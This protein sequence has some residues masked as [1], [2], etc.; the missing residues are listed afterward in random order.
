MTTTLETLA[1]APDDRVLIIHADDVGFCHA[2]NVAVFEGMARGSLTCASALVAAPWF[3][4]TARLCREQP[5][6]DMG[7]HLALNCEHEIFRWR[8]VSGHPSLHAADGGVWRTVDETAAHVSPETARAE[9]FAQVQLA[10]DLGVDVTHVDTH[11]GTVIRPEYLSAYVDVAL[12]F[13]LP[14]FFFGAR[15]RWLRQ[16]GER[17]TRLQPLGSNL[18]DPEFAALHFAGQFPRRLHDVPATAV[19][20][21]DREG[22]PGVRRRQ[23]LGHG[24]GGRGGGGLRCASGRA[25]GPNGRCRP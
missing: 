19:V 17:Q 13:R 8:S 7:V 2:S 3:A 6:A 22:K 11:M 20:G 16:I 18:G 10:L 1:Y 21:R 25:A 15:E 5:R 23:A 9:M 14:I 12:E 24:R 4:E